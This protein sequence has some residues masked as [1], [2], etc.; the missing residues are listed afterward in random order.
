MKDDGTLVETLRFSGQIN[1]NGNQHPSGQEFNP[2]AFF[3]QV[4]LQILEEM[5]NANVELRKCGMASIGRVLVPCYLGRLCLTFGTALLCCVDFE[6][7]KEQITSVI[8]GPPN[9]KEISR[10]EYSLS[11]GLAKQRDSST[12]SVGNSESTQSPAVVASD[13]VSEILQTAIRL[14]Q[15]QSPKIEIMHDIHKDAH[16][17]EFWI[18]LASLLRSY[19]ALHGL[20]SNSRAAVECDDEQITVR[21]GERLLILTRHREIV[22]WVRE[23]G[24]GG[25]LELTDSGSLRGPS[26]EQAMDLAVEQ[27]AREIMR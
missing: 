9:R 24:S 16:F 3:E 18:S 12:F 22:T 19:T 26:G 25:P 13:I 23:N 17:R 11:P 2:C 20:H 7:G 15:K 27:W 14:V 8:V 4:K 5:K 21:H 10:Q 6:A 1:L